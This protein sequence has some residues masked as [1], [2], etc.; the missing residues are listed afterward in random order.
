MKKNMGTA[1]KLIRL[2]IAVLIAVLYL[3]GVIKGTLG[4]VLLA[5]AVIFVLTSLFGF[6]PLYTIFGLNTGK[7]KE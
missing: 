7:K 5:V 6:C 4:I 3:A 1:D 2:I